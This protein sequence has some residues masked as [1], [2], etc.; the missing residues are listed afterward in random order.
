M[1]LNLALFLLQLL[2]IAWLIRNHPI[3]R[4]IGKGRQEI[5]SE[6]GYSECEQEDSGIF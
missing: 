5:K 6:T 2:N 1:D 4:K 3:Q